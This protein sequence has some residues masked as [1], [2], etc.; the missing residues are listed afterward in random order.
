MWTKKIKIVVPAAGPSAKGGGPA[1]RA[2]HVGAQAGSS[3]RSWSCLPLEAWGPQVP[4]ARPA[5]NPLRTLTWSVNGGVWGVRVH[6]FLVCV[7]M[8][9]MCVLGTCVCVSTCAWCV[10]ACV[11]TCAAGMWPPCKATGRQTCAGVTTRLPSQQQAQ[12]LAAPQPPAGLEGSTGRWPQCLGSEALSPRPLPPQDMLRQCPP[13]LALAGLL[14][15]GSGECCGTFWVGKD[16]AGPASSGGPAHGAAPLAP[17]PLPGV[18]QVQGQHVSGLHP[19]GAR[20][21]LVP[22]AGKSL[23]PGWPALPRPAGPLPPPRNR[24]PQDRRQTLPGRG[25]RAGA[26]R[27]TG[28]SERRHRTAPG[29]GQPG[30]DPSGAVPGPASAAPRALEAGGGRDQLHGCPGE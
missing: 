12:G 3:S 2:I 10:G 17:S 21:R 8:Y 24:G 18:H 14:F 22:A 28:L 29:T 1:C 9:V 19:V 11:P 4:A 30:A 26:A 13:L 5:L 7:H 27:G 25:A 6:L 23:T 15:L 20:V 16:G